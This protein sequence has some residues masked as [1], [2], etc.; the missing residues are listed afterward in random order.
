MSKKSTQM[1]IEERIQEVADYLLANPLASDFDL[2]K[3]FCPKYDVGWPQINRYR[4]RAKKLNEKRLNLSRD[5]MATLG[6]SVLLDLLKN[7]SA[8]IRI[9]AEAAL[10][11]IAGYGAPPRIPEDSKGNPMQF[12]PLTVNPADII[13]DNNKEKK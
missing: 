13:G 9:K 1:Q 6:K 8:L 3:V 10:R 11:D 7:P 2:H 4:L 12:V 5:E